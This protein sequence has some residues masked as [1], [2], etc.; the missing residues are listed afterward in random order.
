MSTW[1]IVVAA[2]RGE[3]LGAPV[4][5]AIVPVAGMP[6]VAWSVRALEAV[7]V[8]GIVVALPPQI[9]PPREIDG[10]V[11]VVGGDSRMASV[12]RALERIPDADTV[13]VHDAARPCVT[14]ALV[15]RALDGLHDADGAVC[16][17]PVSDSLKRSD[18]TAVAREGLWRAQTPQAFRAAVLRDAHARAHAEG[19]DATDDAQLVERYGGRVVLVDGDERNIKVTTA[20]DLAIAARLL[21][22]RPG[23]SGVGYDAHAFAEG[24]PLVLG[25]VA[26]PHAR[27]LAGH[28]DADVVAHAI[29]D[30]LL[31]AAA[32]GDIGEHFPS[33]D[34]RWKDAPG[35]TFL[36]AAAGMVASAGYAIASIDA[37][38]VLEAPVIAPFRHEMR[39]RIADAVGVDTDLVSIKATTTDGI[40][41]I[42]GGDGAAAV[43]IVH[44]CER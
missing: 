17:V 42:A 23:R 21:S 28:S 39:K 24:R 2:G 38:V 22:P 33:R 25:C 35:E 14:P 7:P 37:T 8:D 1:A 20:A 6:M 29:V 36:R 44:L 27:G 10:S 11:I 5:K 30:A 16:A 43:A 4:P 13:V 26:I 9:D 31:G 32:L 34:E 12:R 41:A 40:G 18:A 3:R 19:I 15:E